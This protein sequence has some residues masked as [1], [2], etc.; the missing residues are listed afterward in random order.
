MRER[1]EMLG[2]SLRMDSGPGAGERVK[3]R[4]PLYGCK[5]WRTGVR[6]PV[7]VLSECDGFANAPARCCSAR[8]VT[9]KRTQ[10][11]R[12]L[13]LAG[14]WRSASILR[15]IVRDLPFPS[16]ER[17]EVGDARA[18]GRANS[19]H[20]SARKSSTPEFVY[21]AFWECQL[22]AEER[23]RVRRVISSSCSQLSP[24]KE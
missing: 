8:R 11:R 19:I 22:R 17:R 4:V 16:G 6:H 15:G 3:A 1:D 20:R 21:T 5:V 7:H 18:S 24:T 12:E 10:D 9:G 14:F 13:V 2:G 23:R